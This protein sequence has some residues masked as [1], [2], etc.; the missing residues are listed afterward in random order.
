MELNHNGS[1]NKI[2]LH[3][4]NIL[5]WERSKHQKE[6]MNLKRKETKLEKEVISQHTMHKNEYDIMMTKH[7]KECDALVKINE[8][9]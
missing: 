3:S 7:E 8:E 2:E 1:I 4:C 9:K 5:R 6:V